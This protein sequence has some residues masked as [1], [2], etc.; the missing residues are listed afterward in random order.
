MSGHLASSAKSI[1]VKSPDSFSQPFQLIFH[2]LR[3]FVLGQNGACCT[4]QA[5]QTHSTEHKANVAVGAG[6]VGERTEISDV[7]SWSTTAASSSVPW[8]KGQKS[9]VTTWRPHWNMDVCHVYVYVYIDIYIY[10]HKYT[11]MYE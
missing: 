9:Q 1:Q 10:V 3:K 4:D 6:D 11:Y 2:E 5:T 8:L 7:S